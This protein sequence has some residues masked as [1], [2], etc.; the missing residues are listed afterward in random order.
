MTHIIWHIQPVQPHHHSVKSSKLRRGLGLTP[1]GHRV[2]LPSVIRRLQCMT[3][4][5]TLRL[6]ATAYRQQIHPNKASL[7]L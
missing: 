6:P 2:H 7:P 4:G 3:H 5:V 1:K